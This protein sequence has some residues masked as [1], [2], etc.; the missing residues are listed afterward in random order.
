MMVRSA[1]DNA[2]MNLRMA[3]LQMTGIRMP[4]RV[5]TIPPMRRRLNVEFVSETPQVVK[6]KLS[7]PKMDTHVTKSVPIQTQ[8]A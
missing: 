8:R 6:L 4:P 1:A 5:R 2:A 7:V 3:T